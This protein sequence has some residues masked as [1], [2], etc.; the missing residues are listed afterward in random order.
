LLSTEQPWCER[1]SKL[2]VDD[3][4][5]YCYVRLDGGER[6]VILGRRHARS[7]FRSFRRL[8]CTLASQGVRER[9]MTLVAARVCSFP[10]VPDD[11][12]Q[13]S[14]E[15]EIRFELILMNDRLGRRGRGAGGCSRRNMESECLRRSVQSSRSTPTCF[16]VFYERRLRE[17]IACFRQNCI[18]HVHH[19]IASHSQ[20]F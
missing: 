8:S 16:I 19:R 1:T 9:R 12:S 11:L 10:M 6:R 18:T 7:V 17:S 2:H 14:A 20:P 13:A 4:C 5:F 3:R 15:E